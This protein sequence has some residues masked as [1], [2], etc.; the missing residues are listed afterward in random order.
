MT[1]QAKSPDKL[2][3]HFAAMFN[4]ALDMLL[5][6]FPED[7]C[8]RT[9]FGWRIRKEDD[10]KRPEWCNAYA[11]DDHWNCKAGLEKPG[12]QIRLCW[13]DYFKDEVERKKK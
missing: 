4:L 3:E 9:R 12:P 1:M 10:P 11:T 7:A 5:E 13:I 6:T 2:Q 8:P